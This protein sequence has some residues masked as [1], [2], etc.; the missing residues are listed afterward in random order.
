MSNLESHATAANGNVLL[1]EM[2]NGLLEKCQ[3]YVCM[4]GV[5]PTE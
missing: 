2:L 3:V 5:D 4:D 1:A